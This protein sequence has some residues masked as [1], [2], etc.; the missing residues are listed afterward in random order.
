MAVASVADFLAVLEKSKLL[1]PEQLAKAQALAEGAADPAALAK[2]LV[3]QKLVSRWQ[4]AQLLAGRASFFLG[5]YKLIALLGRGGMGS[6]FLAEH[7]TMNRRVALK[8]VPRHIASNRASL[9]RF[10]A[11]ARAIAALDH[12]NIVQAY[13]VDNECDRYF[14]VMEHVEG[15]DLRQVV[16]VDGPLAFDRAADYIRQAADGLA[17]A[18]ARKMI[19]CDIKPSNLLVNPQGVVKILDMGLVRLGGKDESA[20]KPEDRVLGSVDYLAPE[21]ALGTPDFDCR[22]DIYSLGCTLYFLL[23]GHPPFPEGTLAQRLVKHQTQEPRDILQERP[24]A[25]PELVAVCR[26][27]MA[28]RPEDRYQ[29]AE[30]VSAALVAWRPEAHAA[31]ASNPLKVVRHSDEDISAA[32]AGSDAWL[33]DVVPASVVSRPKNRNK[34]QKPSATAEGK[35]AAPAAAALAAMVRWPSWFNTPR[36]RLLAAV[37]AG[38]LLL[39]AAATAAIIAWRSHATA[40]TTRAQANA[41]GADKKTGT[42]QGDDGQSSASSKP[43]GE[44]EVKPPESSDDEDDVHLP[45]KIKRKV[46]TEE[47][48]EVKPEEPPKEEVKPAEKPKEE[49]KPV[50]KPKEEPKPVEK[51]KEPPKPAKK[52]PSLNGLANSVDLPVLGSRDAGDASQPLSLGKIEADDNAALDVKLLGGETAARGSTRFAIQKAKAGEDPGWY[53]STGPKD[54]PV[55]IARVW[56][57]QAEMKFQW[58]ADAKKTDYNYLRNCGL[59]FTCEGMNRLTVLSKTL[60][61]AP[62]VVDLVK[63]TNEVKLTRDYLPTTGVHLKVLVLDKGFPSHTMKAEGGRKPAAPRGQKGKGLGPALEAPSDTVT[64]RGAVDIALIKDKAQVPLRVFFTPG[65]KA[66]RVEMRIGGPT[67][68]L[69]DRALQTLD[70]ATKTRDAMSQKMGN[71]KPQGYDDVTKALK[72]QLDSLKK[73]AGDVKQKKIDYRIFITLTK[74]DENPS[75]ELL[76][77]QTDAPQKH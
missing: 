27:M 77:Y 73:L 6:V 51:P 69:S 62:L 60:T 45:P 8:I 55:K 14:I 21:Q 68:P 36:R 13:S 5:K 57:D 46:K 58:N 56:R 4:A 29:S 66:I 28:K 39:V 10:F 7:V 16:E 18:H 11:E 17:H 44:A 25:P 59:L 2:A 20:A 35:A 70:A 40:G 65:E 9:E 37:A 24:D 19:H 22:A 53:V 49:P 71:N 31:A 54:D 23:T 75:Q 32:D 64:G 50:E 48:P 43:K 33:N 74:P 30:E 42:G 76:L 38:I 63:G 72:E 12:P 15:Q 47:E 61:A 3:L 34:K 67:G 41:G 52:P 1:G 26:Q